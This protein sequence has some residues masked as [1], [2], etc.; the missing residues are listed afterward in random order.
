MIINFFNEVFFMKRFGFYYFIIICFIISLPLFSKPKDKDEKKDTTDKFV[1]ATFTGLNFR[2]IGPAATSGR[3]GDFAVNPNNKSEFYVA[4]SC[5]NVWKT[6]NKGLSFTPIFDSY[7]SYSIGCLALDPNNPFVLWVGSGENN[8]QRS[9]GYGD[10]IYKSTDG[11]KSFTNMGLKKSEHIGK[12][13]ID[14]RNSDVIYVAAQGPLWGPGGDRGL[15]KSTDGGKT[16]E[17]SLKI[18]ENTGV[19]D[20]VFDPRNPD[21]IFCAS[22][23]RRRHVWTLINGGPESAI[24]KSTDAGKTWNKLTNGLPN[25]DMGK[26][27]LAI[28]PSNPD[29]VYATIEAASGQGGFYKSTDRGA[30]WSKVNSFVSGSAQYYQELVCDPSDENVVY[31]LDTY[32]HVTYDGGKTFVRLSNKYRHVD[33][34]ALWIDPD[35]N[36]YLLMGGDGG[37]YESYDRGETWRFFTNLPTTQY[38][39]VTADNSEPFYY[40]YGGT[41]DNNTW[42]GPS[43]TTNSG[44]ITNEDW[45]MVVGGDGYKAVI[46]PKDP[47]IVYGQWQYGNLVRFDRKSGEVF[48]IQPQ[49]EKGEEIRW[50]WDTPLI[51]SHHSNT[52]LYIA[53]NKVFRSDDRGQSWKTISPDLTRQID[54]NKLPVMGKI[55][56]PD[57]VAKNASTSFYGNIIALVESPLNEN[58]IIVGTDDGLLQITEDG[59]KN[60]RKID[61]FPGVPETTYVS[62][63]FTSQFN[64]NVIYATFNNHKNNDF[65]PYVIKSTDRGQTWQSL[66]S[67]LPENGPVWTINEDHKNPDLLFVGTEFGAFFTVDGGKKWIQFKSGLPTIAVRDIEIQRRE[68]DLILGTFGRGIYILDDYTPLRSISKELFDKPYHIFPI[69]DA[70][71]Y[72]EDESRSKNDHGETF[73]RAKNPPFGATFTY[74]VKEKIKTLKEKR[75]EEEKKLEKEGKSIVYPTPAQLKAEDEELKPYLIAKIIDED[76][77]TIRLLTTSINPGINRLTWDLRYPD[78]SPVDDKTDVNKSSGMAVMPGKYKIVLAQSINGVISIVSDTVEFT[79][80]VLENTSLPVKDRKARVEFQKKVARLQNAVFGANNSISAFKTQLAA[81]KNA[82]MLSPNVKKEAIMKVANLEK[83]LEKLNEAI[84][85]DKSLSKRNENQPP[86]IYDRLIYIIWGIWATS[87][88][89]TK[90]QIDAYNIAGDEFEKVLTSLRNIAEKD[91]IE[92]NKELD[93]L[94]SP[95][96]P[97]RIPNWK[98]E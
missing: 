70:L 29:I 60:W 85:G 17:Q 51:I 79:A 54:R 52:R 4:V 25:V 1:S 86:S 84:N 76:G 46:D 34:H 13:L 75:I 96:T 32:T 27:G 67:N 56:G 24:Y 65:K 22:Y 41:Q 80:K 90:T 9:V 18:S 43:R 35:N 47:N 91:I 5:G 42:G 30:S 21:I 71:M 63:V 3:V 58:L 40:V 28:P 77:N 69:K 82:F 87:S 7:G 74:Y 33:D 95:W 62:D 83:E 59:G 15:Y 57:A 20:A 39:R 64:E 94:G 10:G 45:F 93:N 72:N 12:I 98:K 55:W 44:G 31:N 88:E 81:M 16:W 50:N 97:G 37:V 78:T 19:T 61:K 36:N 68:N 73:Y 53:A 92:L 48:Y 8:S 66:S 26:I 38:Y 14:P 2:L 89:Q 23:Q 11:G 6:T 49:P